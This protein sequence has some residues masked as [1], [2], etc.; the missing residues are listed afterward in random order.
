MDHRALLALAAD[1]LRTPFDYVIVGSGAG[2][3]PLAAR[4]ALAGR[5]VLVIEAGSDPAVPVDG[6]NA[7]SAPAAAGTAREVYAVPGYHAAATEDPQM[8]WDFSVRH[9]E[10]DRIQCQDA[11]YDRAHDPSV[12]SDGHKAGIQYPRCAALGG[13]TAHHA[14]IIIRPN[15][16]DWDH[17]A[18]LT[19]DSSWRSDNMQGYFAKIEQCLYY[20]VYRGFAGKLLGRLLRLIQAV[21]TLLNPRAQLD[22]GG[23]GFHGWQPTSFIDPLVVAGIAKNDS[24]FRSVLKDVIWS[25]LRDR[26]AKS[27]FT[28]ALSRLQIIQFLDPNVR[29]PGFE[30]RAH[31]SLISIG[32]D[33]RRR[34]GVREHLLDVAARHPDRLVLLT[35]A[36]ATRVLCENRPGQAAPR[37]IGVEVAH[38]MHLYQASPLYQPGREHSTAQYFARREVILC[39]GAFNT[40][41]LLM[42]SGIGDAAHLRQFGIDGL[43]GPDGAQVAPT[44]DLPG[45]GRNLQ[46]RYEVSVITEMSTEF[47]TLKGVSFMPGDP[48]DVMRLRWLHDQTGL[49]STNGGALAMMMS[50]PENPRKDPDLYVFGIPAAFRGYYWNWSK[51]LFRKF[52]GAAEEQRNLWSWV[53]LKA[54]TGNSGGAVR[55]CSIDPFCTPYINFHSFAEGSP[56][57]IHDVNALCYAVGA[58][59]EINRRVRATRQEVQPGAGVADGSD[60]LANWVQHEAWGHHASGTCRMG[61][62]PWRADV[63]RLLDKRAVLDSN[64]SVHGVL[65]LRVVDASIFPIIPGYF[66]VTPVF[67]ASEKAA[68]AILRESREYSSALE[69]TEA[70]AIHGRRPRD[71]RAEAAG[72][73]VTLPADAVGLAL[74]GG[75]IR[76]ATFCLGVLQALAASQKLRKVDFLSTVSGGGYIGAF[77]G[78]LYTRITDEVIDKAGRVEEILSNTGAPEIWWLRRQANYINGAGRTDLETNVAVLVRNFFA[79]H[80]CL[81]TLILTMFAALRWLAPDTWPGASLAWA[82]GPLAVSSWW[83]VPLL[84]LLLGV[85]PLGVAYWLSPEPHSNRAYPVFSLLAWAT[86]LAGSVAAVGIPALL[87]WGVAGII[88]L[89]V[90]WLWQEVARWRIAQESNDD[91]AQGIAVG[92]TSRSRLTRGMGVAIFAFV[93]TA[94]WLV[95]DSLAARAALQPMIPEMG[96]TMLAATAVLPFVRKRAIGMTREPA[97]D[98]PNLKRKFGVSLAAFTFAGVLLFLFDL[99]AHL[100]FRNSPNVGAWL[101][102]TALF[103]SIV[104]GRAFS[105]LNRSSLQPSYTEKLVRSYLG[106]SNDKRVHSSGNE[107]PVP[108]QVP[109]ADDDVWHHDYHP[110]RHGGP[111]HLINLCVNETVD[112][113]SGRQVREDKGL[114]MCVGPG[115]I[116]VGRRFHATWEARHDGLAA[117]QAIVRAAPVAPD[118]NAFHVL[119]ST[120]EPT[121]TIE[122][123]RLGQWMAISGASFSTGTGRTTKLSFAL[124]SALLNIRLGYWWNSGIA[125]GKRPGR[126][127]P[128]LWRRIKSLPATIFRMQGTLLN[129]CRAYFPG[130]AERHWY[131]SD[132]GHFDN[133]GLYELIRRR[134]PFIIAID[135]VQDQ[136]YELGDMAILTRQVRLDFGAELIW[137]DPTVSRNDGSSGW[138]SLEDAT[139]S[140]VIPPWIREFFNPD[141]IGALTDLKRNGQYCAALARVD[142]GDIK[143]GSWLL[144]LRASLLAEIPHDIR[145]YATTHSWFPN[146]ETADQFFDDD[147]WESYR[148]LGEHEGKVVFG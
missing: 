45:V 69:Q 24:M 132:G 124:L 1:P 122:Q 52:K 125:P 56:N 37:A 32:I 140:A 94:A 121:A 29:S 60:E 111:L 96:W 137:L 19:G 129:E 107:S 114:P 103:V 146:D 48:N 136:R 58:V 77:L 126:Y 7:S 92:T 86:L 11:K 18:R 68:D 13:C 42:L 66:I 5:T 81:A 61:A 90:G 112:Q 3:G 120:D 76:S 26:S 95:L 123:L 30:K 102:L 141:A 88:V 20:A 33:G 34:C 135:S 87:P 72:V 142:Y 54:Y 74:S 118:P 57:F 39:G 104:L 100:A 70:A 6:G 85:I 55:L 40:P 51:E 80:F 2:G 98:Q 99:V 36:H 148:R 113:L 97:P 145:N 16:E 79:V 15:D 84:V 130:P 28:R 93:V 131:L 64:F 53:I 101:L 127:P 139:P 119:A 78:R 73:P 134:L 50:S 108:V 116:S 71:T 35:G 23:H 38:G 17:I 47:T 128:S 144:L 117:N 27:M 12:M 89:L 44:V 82:L 106:A 46:D 63:N 10:D 14:M 8:S 31:L 138:A 21:A 133:T 109:D 75:G 43:R 143:A 41:Q 9:Y 59:R 22:P 4:L 67:M 49:Y 83:P 115:G 62:D 65:G 91:A 105:F 25:G 147:Q 110:E